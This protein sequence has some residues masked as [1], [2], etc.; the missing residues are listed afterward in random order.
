MVVLDSAM[1]VSGVVVVVIHVE[2]DQHV[3]VGSMKS[4]DTDTTWQVASGVR[5]TKATM[6]YASLRQSHVA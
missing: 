3:A 4:R 2:M 6:I 5:N 1:D